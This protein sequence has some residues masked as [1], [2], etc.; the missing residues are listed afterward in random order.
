MDDNPQ[1]DATVRILRIITVALVMGVVA[2]GLYVVF[3]SNALNPAQPPAGP[4]MISYLAAGFALMMAVLH[5]VIPNLVAKQAVSK[6]NGSQQALLGAYQVKTIFALALLEGAAFF[7]LFAL[8]S[9]HQ[10]WSLAIVGGLVVC[11]LARFPTRYMVE[12][13]LQPE[14]I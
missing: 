8:M 12:N 9:E 1:I 2:F 11:M 4:S 13:W 6:S 10:L 14:R 3:G 5:L 7:N